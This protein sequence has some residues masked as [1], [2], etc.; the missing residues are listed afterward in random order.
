VRYVGEIELPEDFRLTGEMLGETPVIVDITAEPVFRSKEEIKFQGHTWD[1][2][3]VI[4]ES[5]ENRMLGIGVKALRRLMAAWGKEGKN[6][7][8]KRLMLTKVRSE[9]AKSG[10][11]IWAEPEPEVKGKTK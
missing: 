11:A 4:V 3:V 2:K 1:L 10:F 6:W 8:G 7:V 9:V 5:G